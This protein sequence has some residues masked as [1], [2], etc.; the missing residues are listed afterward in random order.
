MLYSGHLVITDDFS[1]NLPNHGKT[2]KKTY[3]KWTLIKR[4]LTIKL[5]QKFQIYFK[6]LFLKKISNFRGFSGKRNWSQHRNYGQR[7]YL[8]Y[9]F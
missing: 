1:W 4:T 8:L 2:F 5:P 3:I 9:V 7:G 6:K